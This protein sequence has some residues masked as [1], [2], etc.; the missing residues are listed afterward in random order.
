[1]LLLV[2]FM[3]MQALPWQQ[4][5]IQ[6]PQGLGGAQLSQERGELLSQPVLVFPLML[7]TALAASLPAQVQ[8]KNLIWQVSAGRSSA[9]V[10]LPSCNPNLQVIFY[11]FFGFVPEF[12]AWQLREVPSALLGLRHSPSLSQSKVNL[13]LG[14]SPA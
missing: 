1:M 5:Q 8:W 3:H 4:N 12:P 13:G 10:F 7:V 6:E 11:A 2:C 9:E 14:A